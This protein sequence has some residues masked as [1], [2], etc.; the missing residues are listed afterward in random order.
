MSDPLLSLV[1]VGLLSI[2]CQYLA[3]KVRLPAILPL[4][5]VGIVVGPVFGVLNADDLF[6]DLLFPVVS[7][8]V[9]IIL[10]EGSLTLKFSD[11][12][13]HG[14]MVRNLCSVGVVVTWLVAATAAHYSLDLTWQLSFL[15]GAIVTV[16]GPTVIVPMLRTV[17]P[18]TNL[19]NI[20]RW[21]GIVID[22]IGA[23]LA[24]LVFEFIVASQ[25]TAITHTLIAFGKTIGIGSVLG[26]ASGYLLGL[27]IRKDWIP[28][29]LLN[30]AVLTVILGVFAASNYVAHE[31]GL[32]AVT[33][34]GMVLANM[35]DVDVED[36]LEFKETLSVLLISGLFILLATRLNLQSVVDVGWGSIVVLA[37][38]MFVARPLSVL[39]SSVGTGLKLNELAL[40]SWIAPRGIV[41]AAVSALFSLKLEEIGYEGAGI[42]VPIVFMVIIATVVVQSLT[43]RTVA[44]LLKVRAPAPTGYLIFGG[45]K[46][47]RALATEMI[48]QK[49]DVTIADTN[50]DAI[51]EARM[52]DIPVYFGNPMS[53]HAARHLDLNTFGTVLIMSPYKQLNPLIAYHFEYTMGKDKVWA[54]TN[55]EQS[56]RPSHQVS[57]QYAKKLTLF[58]EGVTYGYLASA[59]ARDSMVKTTRLSEEFT[60][61][62]YIKQYGER[63]TPLIAINAEGKSYT[64]INGNSIQPKAGWRLIS[65]IE[66]ER[67]EEKVEVQK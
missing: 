41:A 13:G 39:A 33:I 37:A 14:N 52:K 58:D 8:S 24:V 25:E 42:I 63:A 15:F 17:R 55:N 12:A 23:L 40:L 27:S 45:S 7:L 65:L 30:T 44:S 62:Q 18:K 46:F 9:A 6:G 26:L 34:S 49:L 29:Y 35:K 66:P 11:I 48:N 47:N 16:T 53:D 60:Y 61:E 5:I 51:R 38:I 2:T 31:S 67:K 56:T 50:W 10:F 19:A 36:I 20:L 21:E 64:F 32:L 1:A 3:Y 28:H 43:S 22:P 57:E 54:L 4:L 59:I